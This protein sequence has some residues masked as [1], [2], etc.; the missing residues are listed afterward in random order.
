MLPFMIKIESGYTID[1]RHKEAYRC[2]RCGGSVSH[3]KEDA[4][5]V[6]C[7][8]IGCNWWSIGRTKTLYY[9]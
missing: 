5:M 3:V 2:P 1:Y 9:E 8:A 6:F 4:Y 7:T